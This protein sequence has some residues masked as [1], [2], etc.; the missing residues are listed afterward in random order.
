M[1]YD[2]G[3]EADRLLTQCARRLAEAGFRLG[4]VVQ[5]NPRRPDRRRCDMRLTDLLG[6]AEIEISQDLGG[7]AGACRLDPGALARASLLVE[8][9]VAAD[10]DLVIV[11]KFG[12]QEAQ[13]G[14]LRSALAGALTSEI[15]VLLGVSS[16]NLDA[17]SAFAGGAFTRLE[18]DQ[19]AIVA[20]C[21]NALRSK[22]GS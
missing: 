9:A 1:I 16:L 12:K 21:Q 11:N 2:E 14:G 10:V 4:G 17:F 13:G 15:P 7:G 3:V 20:W 5:S 6:G 19:D 18:P 22:A 8:R